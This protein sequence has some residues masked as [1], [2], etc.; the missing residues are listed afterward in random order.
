MGAKYTADD[1]SRD[2]RERLAASE[3]V[4]ASRE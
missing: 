3:E 4:I 2:W 1:E